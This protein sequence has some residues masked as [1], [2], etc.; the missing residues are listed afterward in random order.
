MNENS[1]LPVLEA[2]P[3]LPPRQRKKER[4]TQPPPIGWSLQES[5]DWTLP[6]ATSTNHER[7]SDDNI[8][9]SNSNI[10]ND[11][12]STSY[13]AFT[14]FQ[15]TPDASDHR[16]NTNVQ[17]SKP[18]NID[19]AEARKEQH[20]LISL[21]PENT[22][23]HNQTGPNVFSSDLEGIDFTTLRAIGDVGATAGGYQQESTD[24]TPPKKNYDEFRNV[25]CGSDDRRVKSSLPKSETYP[26]THAGV[27]Y[28]WNSNL[29]NNDPWKPFGNA[30][31]DAGIT[32]QSPV[33]VGGLQHEA[34]WPT[35]PFPHQMPGQNNVVSASGTQFGSS[36]TPTTNPFSNLPA[37]PNVV[38]TQSTFSDS[39]FNTVSLPPLAA[40]NGD[41][42]NLR[43]TS[44]NPQ[45]LQNL[46]E[47]DSIS[48]WDGDLA[49]EK[50]ASEKSN[51]LMDF[52]PSEEKEYLSLDSFDPLYERSRRESITFRDRVPSY[53]IGDIN[54]MEAV[55]GSVRQLEDKQPYTSSL[56]PVEQLQAARESLDT[57]TGDKDLEKFL[58]S[59]ATVCKEPVT[60][61]FA[62]PRPP[63]IKVSLGLI[64]TRVL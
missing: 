7:Y 9:G 8:S 59:T 23:R 37:K 41:F 49:T 31:G 62:P 43:Q 30:S 60:E 19:L 6:S 54:A 26:Q 27:Q 2:P 42:V 46:F 4:S 11:W 48:E 58:Q 39:D 56:Y 12:R 55:P 38:G 53:V 1:A 25:F 18:N 52:S 64:S 63:P 15:A 61:V 20:A 33:T 44:T 40:G 36:F 16:G 13:A 21:S 51:D 17:S 50:P 22:L 32:G 35:G 10:Q 28:G 47:L 45:H 34:V 3:P 14:N 5:S 57:Q 24:I 29:F